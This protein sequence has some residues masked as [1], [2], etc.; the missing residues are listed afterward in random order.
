LT[1]VL[2]DQLTKDAPAP[3]Q[4]S[5]ADL[6]KA[7]REA[8]AAQKAKAEAEAPAH[9]NGHAAPVDADKAKELLG[10]VDDLSDE[11]VDALLASMVNEKG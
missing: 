7:V 8:Q 11:E 6:M 4:E 3:K 1:E 2:L 5:T 9:T 10:R